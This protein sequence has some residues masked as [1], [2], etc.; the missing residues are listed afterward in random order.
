MTAEKHDRTSVDYRLVRNKSRMEDA[1]RLR[2]EV[3]T[4]EQSI[5][6]DEDRDGL[7]EHADHIVAYLGTKPVG[8]GRVVYDRSGKTAKIGRMVVIG[9]MRHRGIGRG[10]LERLVALAR[11]RGV[12]TAVLGAQ[13]SAS[14]FYER[15]GFV[16][17]EETFMEVGIPHVTMIR[18]LTT[19]KS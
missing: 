17:T 12:R 18:D 10:I 4:G 5:D 9:E 14:G 15:V 8:T 6:P 19:G 3:F 1:W 2:L 16:R 13:E 7:D 11:A